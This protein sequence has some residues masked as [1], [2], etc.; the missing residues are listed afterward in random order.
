MPDLAWRE[1]ATEGTR[2][3]Y[4]LGNTSL[5]AVLHSAGSPGSQI[6]LDTGSGSAFRQEKAL[7]RVPI[8]G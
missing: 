5:S 6:R 4:G 7:S 8:D 2:T 3:G 1:L